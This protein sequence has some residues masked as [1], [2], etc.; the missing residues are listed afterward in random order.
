MNPTNP[1]EHQTSRLVRYCDRCARRSSELVFDDLS[2]RELCS[3][4]RQE[5][6]R[7]RMRLG[8][9]AKPRS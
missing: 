7:R 9:P 1:P 3:D 8:Q 2:L 4:C 6:A 5:L